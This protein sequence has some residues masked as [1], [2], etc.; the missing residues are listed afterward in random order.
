[1]S[2]INKEEMFGHL[3]GFLKSKGIELQEGPYAQTIQQGC[4]LLTDAVNVSQ[5][6]FGRAKTKLD[7]GL[8]ELRQTIHEK[9]APKPPSAASTSASASSAN[10]GPQAKP[11][12]PSSGRTTRTAKKAPPVKRRAAKK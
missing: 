5:D 3:K 9:T 4:G 6:A 12:R 2:K 7:H 11:S 8:D 1:M 10:P